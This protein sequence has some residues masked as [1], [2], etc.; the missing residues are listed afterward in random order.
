MCRAKPAERSS[1]VGVTEFSLSAFFPVF[2]PPASHAFSMSAYT[3]LPVAYVKKREERVGDNFMV[4]WRILIC[5]RYLLFSL[6]L[7]GF[8]IDTVEEHIWESIYHTLHVPACVQILTPH[9]RFA[10]RSR[11]WWSTDYG[12]AHISMFFDITSPPARTLLTNFGKVLAL[13][14]SIL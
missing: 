13:S 4:N 5:R 2:G 10:W 6:S 7:K 3:I 1:K 8:R 9:A 11:K 14:R 12:G